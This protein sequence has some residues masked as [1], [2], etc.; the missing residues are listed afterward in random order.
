MIGSTLAGRARLDGHT[1]HLQI[2]KLE[3]G[4]EGIDGKEIVLIV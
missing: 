3:M 2:G 1:P 4:K